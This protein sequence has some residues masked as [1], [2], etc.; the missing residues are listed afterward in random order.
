MTEKKH[1]QQEGQSWDNIFFKKACLNCM[2]SSGLD[3]TFLWKNFLSKLSNHDTYSKEFYATLYLKKI[4]YDMKSQ[5]HNCGAKGMY[6][7]WDVRFCEESL[8]HRPPLDTPQTQILLTKDN[9]EIFGEYRPI[10]SGNNVTN[11]TMFE[12]ARKV[13]DN[14]PKSQFKQFNEGLVDIIVYQMENFNCAPNRLRYVGF[15]HKEIIDFINVMEE[16]Y[17]EEYDIHW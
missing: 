12:V 3:H 4:F 10:V 16:K 2:T 13:I 14:I 15:S 17:K 6:D 8:Y 1:I 9:G 7:I 11:L 5:C